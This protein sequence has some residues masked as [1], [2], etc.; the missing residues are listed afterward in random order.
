MLRIWDGEGTGN[1]VPHE[2]KRKN[3]Q[4]SMDKRFRCHLI[5][6]KTSVCRVNFSF[7]SDFQGSCKLF[8]DGE[9][10]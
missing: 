9:S 3:F 5:R 4:F 7:L 2:P 6:V 8:D 10:R 1:T